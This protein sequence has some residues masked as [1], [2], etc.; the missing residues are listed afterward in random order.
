[1]AVRKEQVTHKPTSLGM[2]LLYHHTWAITRVVHRILLPT[3]NAR[4][5]LYGYNNRNSILY[6]RGTIHSKYATR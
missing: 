1:M 5:E 3:Y 2:T 4:K 6:P